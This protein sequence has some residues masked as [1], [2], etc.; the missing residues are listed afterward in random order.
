MPL[1]P[2]LANGFLQ[3]LIDFFPLTIFNCQVKMGEVFDYNEKSG[4]YKC[5]DAEWLSWQKNVHVLGLKEVQSVMNQKTVTVSR[6][7][8]DR[9]D[10]CLFCVRSCRR[11]AIWRPLLRFKSRP[12]GLGERK[13]HATLQ[14]K[15]CWLAGRVTH[16]TVPLRRLLEWIQIASVTV[17]AALKKARSI[18]CEKGLNLLTFTVPLPTSLHLSMNSWMSIS[19]PWQI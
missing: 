6:F 10:V 16:V 8:R 15:V 19:Q 18:C 12:S 3:M 2:H 5:Q 7:D 1:F 14:R 11:F 17:M 9:D 4:V 13:K